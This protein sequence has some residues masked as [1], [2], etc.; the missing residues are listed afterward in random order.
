MDG[1]GK[2]SLKH[3]KDCDCQGQFIC[4]RQPWRGEN[5]KVKKI[6]EVLS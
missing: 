6:Q 5:K 1:G 3:R 4:E 2:M